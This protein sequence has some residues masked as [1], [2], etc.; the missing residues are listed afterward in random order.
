[1][2]IENLDDKFAR[3]KKLGLSEPM[4]NA[5]IKRNIDIDN[6]IDKYKNINPLFIAET[7]IN[8]PKEIKRRYA[9]EAN[10]QYIDEIFEKL[11]NNEINKEAVFEILVELAQGKKVNFEKYKTKEIDLDKEIK[12]LIN[13]K[14]GLSFSAYM[15]LLMAKHRGKV[16][17]KKISE[18]LNKYLNKK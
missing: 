17:G 18:V 3:Y 5:I 14:P 6:F 4:I 11:N 10:F 16:D 12:E 2:K 9:L 15:G 1:M 7:L 8:A 13:Q